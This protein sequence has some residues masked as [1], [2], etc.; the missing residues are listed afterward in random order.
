M[1]NSVVID[2]AAT[3][4]VTMNNFLGS[5]GDD[6]PLFT[7]GTNEQTGLDDLVALENYLGAHNPY[8][9]VETVRITRVN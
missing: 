4:R 6:F 5:G 3:Y 8:T 7:Q 1:L 2:P 9:P